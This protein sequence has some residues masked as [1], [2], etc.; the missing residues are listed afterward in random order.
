[1]QKSNG[2]ETVSE[3]L[4]RLV[5][6]GYA[7]SFAA[8]EEGQIQ[9]SAHHTYDAYEFTVEQVARFEGTTDL[10]DESAIFALRHR[11]GLKGT[12]LVA[13]GPQMP[14]EEMEVV[15]RLHTKR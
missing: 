6:S 14:T 9:D 13:F 12:L 10:E 8:K 15:E 1:M 7:E 5:K 4:V 11:S 3:A 2:M